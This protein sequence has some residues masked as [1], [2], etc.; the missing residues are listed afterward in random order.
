MVVGRGP[1]TVTTG[2]GG[3]AVVGRGPGPTIVTGAGGRAVVGRGPTIV[4]GAG[5]P[6]TTVGLGCGGPGPTTVTVTV[7]GLGWMTGPGGSG[8]CGFM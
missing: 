8:G 1:T 4:T 2:A 3:R 5:G 6:T 7:G